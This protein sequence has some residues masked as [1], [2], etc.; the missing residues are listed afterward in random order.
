MS[1]QQLIAQPGEHRE[2]HRAFLLWLM[3]DP[4]QRSARGTARAIGFSE[5]MVRRW[6]VE[7]KW[8]DRASAIGAGGDSMAARYYAQ[9]YHGIKASKEVGVIQS[10]MQVQYLPP[11]A[12]A[13]G[14]A[15]GPP[16]APPP[17]MS[18]KAKAVQL[19]E[20][21]AAEDKNV[22]R[23]RQLHQILDATTA[24]VGE[25]LLSGKLKPSVQ[26]LLVVSRLRKELEVGALPV[27]TSNPMA[28]SVRVEQATAKGG[29]VL[30]ALADDHEELGLILGILATATEASNVVPFPGGRAT[31]AKE[32][33][34]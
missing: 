2:A 1:D 25:A 24:R 23:K 31:P 30:A 27:G 32:A 11:D 3:Q 5:A 22:R 4:G 10:R 29:D 19:H 17:P 13:P 20:T 14:L 12:A 28:S 8:M 16:M 18:E 26:D 33:Q 21:D 9:H 6:M 15:S 7:K 34:G